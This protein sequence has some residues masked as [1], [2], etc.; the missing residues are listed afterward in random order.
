MAFIAGY[1]RK[2]NHLSCKAV[3]VVPL[4]FMLCAVQAVIAA[5]GTRG[6]GQYDII[7]KQD[8]FNPDRGSGGETAGGGFTSDKGLGEHYQIYGIITVGGK[9]RAFVKVRPSSGVVFKKAGGATRPS[10]FRTVSIG[11]LIDGWKVADITPRGI[12]LESGNERVFVGIFESPK[13]ERQAGRPVNIS[14]P[15][16][17]PVPVFPKPGQGRPAR[18]GTR[19]VFFPQGSRSRIYRGNVNATGLKPVAPHRVK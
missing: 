19:K 1:I 16:T 3:C 10:N 6:Q 14:S 12:I 13:R 18:G 11:D 2:L 17:R 5:E 8:P 9:K 15:S 7:I 4:T